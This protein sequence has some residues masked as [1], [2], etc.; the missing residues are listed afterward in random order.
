MLELWRNSWKGVACQNRN[1][2]MFYW[3][4]A[5]VTG[6]EL[7]LWSEHIDHYRNPPDNSFRHI[8]NTAQLTNIATAR[9]EG[10]SNSRFDK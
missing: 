8:P 5:V 10:Y 2:K 9:I 1:I 6:W 4:V 7:V 3:V